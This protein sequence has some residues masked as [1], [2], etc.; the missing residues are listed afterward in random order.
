[1]ILDLLIKT[2]LNHV[3]IFHSLVLLVLAT[4]IRA[5]KRLPGVPLDGGGGPGAVLMC[6]VCLLLW[7]V[8]AAAA[9]GPIKVCL[10]LPES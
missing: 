10:L 9:G 8:G 3:K 2:K 1:M 4:P 6:V 5:D 7:G